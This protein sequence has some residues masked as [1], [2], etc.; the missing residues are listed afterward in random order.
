M[1]DAGQIHQIPGRAQAVGLSQ[2][3]DVP[4]HDVFYEKHGFLLF[5]YCFPFHRSGQGKP[6]RAARTADPVDLHK[7]ICLSV[8]LKTADWNVSWMPRR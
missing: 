5:A 3:E 2:G 6:V 1:A 7:E 8:W 4:G